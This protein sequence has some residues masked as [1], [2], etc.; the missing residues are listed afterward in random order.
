M[1]N[2]ENLVT[3]RRRQ[4]DIAQ[5]AENNEKVDLVLNEQSALNIA[6]ESKAVEV[7]FSLFYD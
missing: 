6:E 1:Y 4:K 7:A 2:S 5:P 3:A